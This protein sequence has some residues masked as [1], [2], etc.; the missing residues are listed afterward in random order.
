MLLTQKTFLLAILKFTFATVKEAEKIAETTD[1]PAFVELSNLMPR[2]PKVAHQEDPVDV[3]YRISPVDK[4]VKTID[5]S[6]TAEKTSPAKVNNIIGEIEENEYIGKSNL[7]VYQRIAWL[8]YLA[9]VY[10][11]ADD[12]VRANE[13][14]QRLWWW[15]FENRFSSD[16]T[17]V[18]CFDESIIL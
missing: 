8:E 3:P 16:P 7:V 18:Q 10:I 12:F 4:I 11:E 13:M 17:A 9:G 15:T 6:K 5:V 14:I 2:A 1:P